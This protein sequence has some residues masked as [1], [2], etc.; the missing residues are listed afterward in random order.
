MAVT[1]FQVLRR[2]VFKGWR[3]QMPQIQHRIALRRMGLVQRCKQLLQMFAPARDDGRQTRLR[4][5][6]KI[7]AGRD[8][9]IMM[10]LRR[11]LLR[12]LFAEFGCGIGKQQAGAALGQRGVRA[13]FLRRILRDTLRLGAGV[14]CAAPGTGIRQRADLPADFSQPAVDGVEADFGGGFF[15]ICRAQAFDQAQCLTVFVIH[16][17]IAQHGVV[18]ALRD[19]G[20]GPH[21]TAADWRA[22]QCGQRERQADRT[23]VLRGMRNFRRQHRLEA[24]IEQG[25]VEMVAV[26]GGSQLLRRFQPG[27]RLTRTNPQ[28]AYRLKCRAVVVAHLRQ[29][30]VA[31]AAIELQRAA[32]LHLGQCQR[33]PHAAPLPAA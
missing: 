7:G 5:E 1:G 8:Q 27:Q 28:R 24:G 32:G 18:V 3:I 16:A 17:D 19:A 30:A 12:Q 2:A 33:R 29:P 31:G 11:Q 14:C 6:G 4:I 15:D 10:V 9:E 26:G 21:A 25:R 20:V 13:G 23:I 22:A